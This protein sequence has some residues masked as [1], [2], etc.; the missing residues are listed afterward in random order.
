[1]DSLREIRLLRAAIHEVRVG[2][3]DGTITSVIR[4]DVISALSTL[5]VVGSG[6]R[7]GLKDVVSW[8]LDSDRS[9]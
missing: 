4:I 5:L 6:E 3:L 1:M 8:I 9:S 7:F 2:D